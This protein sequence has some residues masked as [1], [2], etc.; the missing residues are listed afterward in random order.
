MRS[1]RT[2]KELLERIR[3][4]GYTISHRSRHRHVRRADTGALVMTLS[5]SSSDHRAVLNAWSLFRRI[6]AAPAR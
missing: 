2:E 3:E 1:P 4:A 5:V 6:T